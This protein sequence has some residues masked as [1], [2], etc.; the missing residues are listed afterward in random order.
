MRFWKS[1][2]LNAC[3]ECGTHGT[4]GTNREKR[5]CIRQEIREL[6]TPIERK[7]KIFPYNVLIYKIE[8]S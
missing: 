6:D 3:Y 5:C 1:R 8:A 4:D 7:S 2:E